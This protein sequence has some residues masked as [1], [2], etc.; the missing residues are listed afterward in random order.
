M[1]FFSGLFGG[2]GDGTKQAQKYIGQMNPMLEGY[3]NPYI[4]QG[5]EAQGTLDE[6]FQRMLQDP[7]QYQQLFG[8]NYQ[9]SPG[10]EFQR[11]EALRGANQAAAAG[12][13]LGTAAHQQGAAGLATGLA[14]QDYWKYFGANQD[15]FN[16]G[17]Q[18]TQDFYNKG[19]DATNQLAGGKANVLGSQANL[20]YTQEQNANNRIGSLLGAGIGAAGYALG[21]IPGGAASTY[22][23]SKLGIGGGNRGFGSG[24]SGNFYPTDRYATGRIGTL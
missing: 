13:M 22:L 2:G 16:Q 1:G 14:N 24:S 4:E 5:Q 3:Y 6:Q 18:G 10:Y 17:L 8:G 11:N 15:I 20:A 23:G 12:G 19:Y 7:S 9:Q 21:G